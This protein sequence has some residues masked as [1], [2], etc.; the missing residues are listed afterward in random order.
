VG[1]NFFL[2]IALSFSNSFMSNINWMLIS[3][4]VSFSADSPFLNASNVYKIY[5]STF[6]YWYTNISCSQL[7]NVWRY[8]RG[9]YN[10]Q[11]AEEQKTKWPKENVQKNKQR[12]TKHAHKTK[13][14]VTRTPLNPGGE[15]RCSEKSGKHNIFHMKKILFWLL[16]VHISK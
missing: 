4:F 16:M 2:R 14:R 3:L 1:A 12:S 10:P 8:H 9:N 13:V 15:F 11:I 6:K 5:T 7:R